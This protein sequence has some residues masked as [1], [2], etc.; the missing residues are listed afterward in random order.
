MMVVPLRPLP[1]YTKNENNLFGRD[2]LLCCN[3]VLIY[4]RCTA[5][6]YRGFNS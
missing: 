4:G 1:G 2:S 6:E 3:L 5:K